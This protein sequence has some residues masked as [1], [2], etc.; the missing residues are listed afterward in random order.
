MALWIT[1]RFYCHYH[2]QMLENFNPHFKPEELLQLLSFPQPGQDA[3][4]SPKWFYG[5]LQQP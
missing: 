4:G 2:I 5:I 3:K 1:D